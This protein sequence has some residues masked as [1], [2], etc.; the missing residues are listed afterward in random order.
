[1]QV[2]TQTRSSYAIMLAAKQQC[3]L[4]KPTCVLLKA[5]TSILYLAFLHLHSLWKLSSMQWTTH[6]KEFD[7]LDLRVAMHQYWYK[8]TARRE[9]ILQIYRLVGS[10]SLMLPRDCLKPC[11]LQLFLA[12]ILSSSPQ[13]MPLCL[14]VSGQSAQI[15]RT[16]TAVYA[17]LF[18]LQ[19]INKKCV[20]S[21]HETS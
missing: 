2:L 1:M 12:V 16:V 17:C 21:W 7:F 9:P 5:A 10:M 19:H 14:Y 13:G 3:D 4:W 8:V 15:S 18:I 6:L 20:G 11:A